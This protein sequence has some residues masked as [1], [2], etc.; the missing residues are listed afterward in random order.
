MVIHVLMTE[1]KLE[2]SPER[3]ETLRQYTGSQR[4][5]TVINAICLQ[6]Y[7]ETRSLYIAVAAVAT[8]FLVSRRLELDLIRDYVRRPAELPN[9]RTAPQ[10]RSYLCMRQ[11]L[12][13]TRSPTPLHNE[14]G[15]ETAPSDARQRARTNK[16]R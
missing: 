16:R 5:G 12:I 9:F 7:L 4:C 10:H 3:I 6:M 1:Q 2:V 14:A 11:C 8:C 13:R 15:R